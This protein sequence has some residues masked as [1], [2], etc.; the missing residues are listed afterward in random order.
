MACFRT[1]FEVADLD[2]VAVG[3]LL[4]P[5]LNKFI[6][7]AVVRISEVCLVAEYYERKLLI[8]FA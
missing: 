2:V 7:W 6:T 3:L 8:N 5:M 4:T 1:R